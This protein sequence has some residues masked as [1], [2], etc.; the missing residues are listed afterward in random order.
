M[1][2]LLPRAAAG[3]PVPPERAAAIGLKRRAGC[4]RAVGGCGSGSGTQPQTQSK[5]V[6]ANCDGAKHVARARYRGLALHC[7]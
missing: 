3:A 2:E 7:G 4:G 6:S 5:A 1:W